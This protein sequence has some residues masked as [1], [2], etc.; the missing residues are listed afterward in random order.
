MARATRVPLVL[1][2]LL[3]LAAAAAWWRGW[4]P[5]PTELGLLPSP[6]VSP[7]TAAGTTAPPASPLRLRAIR[8]R[9]DARTRVSVTQ[10][11]E[12]EAYY[13]VQLFA[14]QGGTVTLLEKEMGDEV[15]AG[16]VVL[17]LRETGAEATVQLTAPIDGVITSRSV[18]PGTFVPSAGIVPGAAPLLTISRTDIV[19]VTMNVPDSF[20]PFV[21]LDS[22]V[23]I[24]DPAAWRVPTIETRLTRI[25]PVV[26]AS[27]RTLKVQVELFNGPRAD[28][29]ELL[30][31]QQPRD[32]PDL[33]SRKPP[34][35]PQN[36][37]ADQSAGLVPG[38]LYE[39]QLTLRDLGQIPVIPS[40]SVVRRRGLTS[41]YEIVAGRLVE[42]PVKI[43]LDDGTTAYVKRVRPRA[44]GAA[45]ESPGEEDWAGT[46]LIAWGAPGDL[47]A[48]RAVEAT[49]TDW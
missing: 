32:Y 7:P 12:V 28:Y 4:L 40:S 20:I 37:T 6:P 29:D 8:P 31:E 30:A 5:G 45:G 26:R 27:D 1:N 35:F 34:E 23:T 9:R 15:S 10:P 43:Q 24:R 39:M 18:D 41:V 21:N 22:Q 14:E 48:G 36:L 49:P 25:S 47:Q 2:L 13:R 42:V 3:I 46:E 44:S 38:M 11:A 33:K 17:E 19:T 16:E